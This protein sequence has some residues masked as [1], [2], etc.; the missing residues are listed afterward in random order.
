MRSS[1]TYHG[2]VSGTPSCTS[3][4]PVARSCSS[5]QRARLAGVSSVVSPLC[6]GRH[7]VGV[8]CEAQPFPLA[9]RRLCFV[10]RWTQALFGRLNQMLSDLATVAL[11]LVRQVVAQV[12]PTTL[13]AAGRS[14]SLVATSRS[15]K[16]VAMGLA[17]TTCLFW[18]ESTC[19]GGILR[20]ANVAHC[21]LKT[22]R[23]SCS[24]AHRCC[25]ARTSSNKNT[26]LSYEDTPEEF[27]NMVGFFCTWFSSARVALSLF[28]SSPD[29]QRCRAQPLATKHAHT[30]TQIYNLGIFLIAA[31]MLTQ[32]SKQP[33]C[34]TVVGA[35]PCLLVGNRSLPCS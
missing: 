6:G 32:S 30:H 21:S 33:P 1:R 12:P 18:R 19:R 4:E 16:V 20:A 9:N 11:R 34:E 3:R 2:F 13:L 5:G 10:L 23:S 25:C 22:C 14:A 28:A 35:V 27:R 31:G 24:L 15:T 29:R 7:F 17:T 26:S 8:P